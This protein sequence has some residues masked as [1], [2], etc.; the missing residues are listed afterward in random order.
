LPNCKLRGIDTGPVACI[1]AF[2]GVA[3]PGAD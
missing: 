3:R 2:S 1:S